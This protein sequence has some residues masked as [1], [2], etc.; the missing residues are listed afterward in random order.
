MTKNEQVRWGLL[1]AFVAVLLV[2]IGI[3]IGRYATVPAAE[4]VLLPPA[5]WRADK[6]LIVSTDD[7]YVMVV[8]APDSTQNITLVAQDDPYTLARVFRALKGHRVRIEIVDV[9][10]PFAKP[11]TLKGGKR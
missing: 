4:R 7:A 5:S 10:Q 2:V 8:D 1:A 3:A 9:M 11:G 6:G